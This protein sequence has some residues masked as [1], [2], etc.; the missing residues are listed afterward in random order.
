MIIY[1]TGRIRCHK[2][3]NPN[4]SF[5]YHCVSSIVVSLIQWTISKELCVAARMAPSSGPSARSPPSIPMEL[6]AQNR[7]K[8]VQA[9]RESLAAS[10]RPIRGFVLLQ[11]SFIRDRFLSLPFLLFFIWIFDLFQGG[12]EQTR[13]CTD[14]I[15]LFRY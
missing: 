9:L 2:D 14:H 12:E 15:E 10:S 8:L 11:V 5:P 13:Y 4:S 1:L 7:D 3:P 6:Y